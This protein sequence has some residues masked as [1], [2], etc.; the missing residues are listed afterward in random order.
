MTEL[1]IGVSGWTYDHWKR[2]TF[3]PEGLPAKRELEYVTRRF[4]SVEINGSFYSL[5]RPKTYERYREVSPA[6][7][8]FA[9]KGGRFITH[10]KKLHDVR[11]PLANFFASGVLRL[12][13]KLGPVLWQFPA[14]AWDVERVDRFLDLLPGDAEQASRLARRHDER[15][16]GR[17]SMVVHQNRPIRHAFEFRHEHFLTDEVARMLERRD[18]ALVFSDSGDWPYTEEITASWVYVRLHG[19]PHTYASDYDAHRLDHWAERV[20]AWQAGGEP[21]DAARLTDRPPP[22]RAPR[23]VYVYLD[24]DHRARAPAN[25][26]ALM[27]RLGVPWSA[28]PTP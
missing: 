28:A 23:D 15:V 5:L 17:A 18:A 16:T 8:L 26:R 2:G 27:E 14:M 10:A 20:R 4:N 22:G 7:F 13:E 6:A 9:V 24:N 1:R 11:A 3:Y 19:S 21:A 25:A 12:E